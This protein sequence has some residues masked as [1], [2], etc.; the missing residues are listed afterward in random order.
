MGVMEDRL[1]PSPVLVHTPLSPTFSI[2]VPCYRLCERRWII[3]QCIASIARQ[4]FRDHE[5]LLVDDGSPDGTPDVLRQALARDPLLAARG[6]VLVLA[7][8]GGVCAAR[9]AG[10]DAALGQ[11]VA[12]LDYDDMWQPEY[13]ARI[14]DAA[15]DHPETD[16]FLAGT[17][18]MR[19]LGGE[20]RVRS[21]GPLGHLNTITDTRFKA[22]HL[23]H[24]Y[25]VA[26][27]S[28]VVVARKLYLEHPELKFDMALSRS[29]AEDI[30]FGM[31]LLARGIRPWYVDEPLCVHRRM[32]ETESRGQAAFLWVDERAVN[33][34]ISLRAADIIER[35]VVAEQPEFARQVR[36]VRERLNLEFDLKREYR[37]ASHWFGLRTCLR[38]PR[39][40]KT[41]A[42]L[43][44]TALLVRS[45]FKSILWQYFFRTGGDDPYARARVQ[46]LLKSL[47]ASPAD[48]A[49]MTA[50]RCA[51]G[52]W[53]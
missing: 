40:F 30:L 13:L 10:I 16:V 35:E 41:L 22:W 18:F 42:R 7:E 3:E 15:V 37:S 9:N 34:Y 20:V 47:R 39:G 46:A 33:D 12:F 4:T 51:S 25:P 31:Q 14:H 21:S 50:A 8:N 27:G 53:A 32:M 19:T 6:R 23:L 11:Y 28:A 1:I 5:L 44:G 52:E 24:N 2:I 45:P 29:T 43:V 36:A 26:M 48:G 38:R 17:D 49:P